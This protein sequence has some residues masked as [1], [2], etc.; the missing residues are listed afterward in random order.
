VLK[1]PRLTSKTF[2]ILKFIGSN[3][4]GVRSI[5]VEKFIVSLSDKPWDP[6]VRAGTWGITLYGYAKSV[7]LYKKYCTKVNDRWFLTLETRY[8]MQMANVEGPIFARAAA[9][10]I[11]DLNTTRIRDLSVQNAEVLPNLPERPRL[12]L[13]VVKA[14]EDMHSARDALAAVDVQLSELN[15]KRN[16]AELLFNSRRNAVLDALGI[17]V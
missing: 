10:T 15:A 6:K 13:A 9:S 14:I 16:L 5:D 7:G 17:A 1:L 8:A 2:K 3:Q 4:N 11:G 12:P